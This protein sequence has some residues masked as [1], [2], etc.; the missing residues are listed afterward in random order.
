MPDPNRLIFHLLPN[1]HLDPVWLWDWREGLNEGLTTV[2]SV[3][4]L[5]DEFPELTFMRGESVIYEHIQK[6]DLATFKRIRQRIEEGR[7]DVVGGTVIQPDTNLASTEVLCRQYERGLKY[8]KENLG[9]R[10][11]VAWLADSFGHTAGLPNIFSAF[12]IEGFT[13][14]RPQQKQFPLDSPAFWWEGDWKNRI[15]CYRQHW[16]WYC[17][18]RDNVVEILDETLCGAAKQNLACVG[19]LFGLGNH[20]G[21]PSRRHL[22]DVEQWRRQHPKV[23]VRFS[24][25]HGFFAELTKEI[26]SK[27]EL[28]IPTVRGEFGYCLRGCYSSVQKFKSLYRNGESQVAGAEV[29]RSIIGAATE[30]PTP[31]LAEAW[32]ALLFNA[33]HDIL[34]GSSIERAIE[35]QTAWM[36]LARHRSTQAKFVALNQLAVRVDTTVPPA[37]KPDVATDVPVVVWN[38]LPRPFGGLVEVEVQI[39]WRPIWKFKDRPQEM[40]VVVFDH[41]ENPA[42]FQIVHTEHGS[43][44]NVPWRR[45]VVVPVEIPALG[46]TTLRIGWRDEPEA[47]PVK[48]VCDAQ[49]DGGTTRISNDE[50]S[51][52]AIGNKLGIR[53][54]GENF[55]SSGR[56]LDIHVVEDPWGSWGGM[57]EEI[58]NFDEI[59]EVWSLEQS[60]ILEHGPLRVK[61][62]T[63]WVGRKS[64]LDL[65]FVLA[66]G[67]PELKVEGRMLWNERSARVKLVLPC[68]G[69]LEYDVPGGKVPRNEAGQVPGGRWV[70]RSEAGKTVG[71]VSDVL[72]DFD[73]TP[74]ELRVTLARAS[75]YANDVETAP[76][77][78]VWQ[79]AVDCG[80]LKFQF[81][82][83]GE[84]AEPD[85]VAD[86]LLFAPSFVVAPVGEGD[87]SRQGS[88][89][90]VTPSSVRLLSLEELAPGK[91]QVR[92]QNRSRRTSPAILNLGESRLRLGE[93]GPEQIMTVIVEKHRNIWRNSAALEIDESILIPGMPFSSRSSCSQAQ[94]GDV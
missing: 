78:K 4:N 83:F 51:V 94:L 46:W 79:P 49:C 54:N 48:P 66:A 25:L 43:M 33:F 93:L 1:A 30:T 50:W 73:A 52:E 39:D 18:E 32:D 17:S 24:T 40:P 76:G 23:E 58:I 61:L 57:D 67:S 86:S 14:T 91:L 20:G 72:S 22:Q 28:A 12:G 65:T 34:P 74:E 15:L 69:E 70:V 75:R 56:D 2:R 42:P 16:M 5:M 37:R 41:A 81:C 92:V 8:F 47:A 87:W 21:G 71:F 82:L 59:R 45:R 84:N 44:T 55:F 26:A 64:W 3:L 7:W 13:F 62:W 27:P 11:T 85:H 60:E 80:E 89:G 19:V 38:P 68:R 9:V 88:L 63:R 6:T 90:G 53:R 36:G 10:P 29:T 77:D 31:N 35:D